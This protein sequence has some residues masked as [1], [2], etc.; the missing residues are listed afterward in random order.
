MN[1][2]SPAPAP[3]EPLAERYLDG[4][5]SA[6]EMAEFNR[7][8]QSD[9][10][11]RRAFI[12]LLNLDSSLAAAAAGDAE[13]IPPS[14]QVVSSVPAEGVSLAASMVPR[15]RS[16]VARSVVRASLAAGLL[17]AV[18]GSWWW[19]AGRPTATVVMEAGAPQFTDGAALGRDRH[20]LEAGTIEL[21]TARG[22]RVFIEAPAE[23]QFESADRLRMFRG[24]LSA[25]VSPAAKGFTVVT[26]AG[27]AVDLGTRFGVDVPAE[28]NAEIHVFEGEVVA[29]VPGSAVRKNLRD[30]D[31]VSF[32][33]G[34]GVPRELRSGAF[35]QAHE[36]PELSAGLAAGQQRTA[37]SALKT[38]R[39]DPDLIALLDFE[40][41]FSGS[42]KESG[43]FRTMQGRWPGSCAPEF[44][45]VGDHLKLDVGGDRPYPQMTLAAWVRL[46]RLGAPYQSLLHTD[47]WNRTPGQVHWMV[48]KNATMRLALSRNTMAPG[49]VETEHPDSRTSVLPERGRWTHLAVTYDSAT[50]VVRFYLNGRFDKESRQQVAH[51]AR[52][53]PAQ[54]GNWDRQDRKLSGRIDELLV[55]GR[56]MSDDE[57]RALYEAGTPYR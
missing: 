46:D 29:A 5:I 27:E 51:P 55:L 1:A 56:V 32:H 8:L 6:A 36:F 33:N 38:L 3:G 42:S 21:K 44:V 7:L 40:A 47:G 39:A 41:D 53:G 9:S 19:L 34:V 28:G 11:A 18:G 15:R 10:A 22:A 52:F 4:T 45:E 17:F 26:L 23:F 20:A 35:I 13:A 31:A 12:E 24:R 30:G 49:S 57:V 25:E 37:A 50:G 54:I 43:E 14:A 16:S 2:S 48:T